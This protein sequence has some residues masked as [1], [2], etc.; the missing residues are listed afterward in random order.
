MTRVK[1][2]NVEYTATITGLITDIVWD[3]RSSK[4]ITLTMAYNDA[5]QLFVDDVQWSIVCEDM[6]DGMTV[7]SEFDN[8]DYCVAGD[9]VDHRD[10]T[11]TIKMGKMTDLEEAYELLYGED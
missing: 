9:I 6:V 2:N 10:G 4:S 7:I 11:L 8:S 3:N 1:I 5:V